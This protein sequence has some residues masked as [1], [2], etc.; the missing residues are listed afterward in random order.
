MKRNITV[1][2]TTKKSGVFNQGRVGC[3]ARLYE[4]KGYSIGRTCL[5]EEGEPAEMDVHRVAANDLQEVM[6]YMSRREKDFDIRSITLVGLIVMLSGS[7]Y[8]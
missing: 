2:K 5:N 1:S 7:S 4:I 8:N 3:E 6:L